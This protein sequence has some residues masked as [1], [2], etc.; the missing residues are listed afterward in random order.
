MLPEST[1]FKLNTDKG[2]AAARTQTLSDFSLRHHLEIPA[3]SHSLNLYSKA[4]LAKAG[5]HSCDS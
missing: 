5:G 2:V 4:E 1:D 3:G